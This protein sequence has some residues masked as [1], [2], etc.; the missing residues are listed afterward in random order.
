VPTPRFLYPC[1]SLLLLAG[2]ATRIS[3]PVSMGEG[4]Y[5]MSGSA[6]GLMTSTMEVVSDVQRHASSFCASS[7]GKALQVVKVDTTAPEAVS[8]PEGRLQFRCVVA[9]S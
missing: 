2:C 3:E 9:T 6:F 4:V 7:G 1:A 8:F 5:V